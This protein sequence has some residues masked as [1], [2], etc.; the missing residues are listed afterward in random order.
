MARFSDDLLFEDPVPT[1][2]VYE[3]V[4]CRPTSRS[5]SVLRVLRLHLRQVRQGQ[6]DHLGYWLDD[7]DVLS[8]VAGAFPAVPPFG[9]RDPLIHAGRWQGRGPPLPSP[10]HRLLD[11]EG[12]AAVADFSLALPVS[13]AATPPEDR[14][15][16]SRRAAFHNPRRLM[17]TRG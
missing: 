6:L 16:R 8:A 5:G 4:S 13:A 7:P 14:I 1:V 12:A 2:A 17:E 11:T 9:L 3:G 10:A 15:S